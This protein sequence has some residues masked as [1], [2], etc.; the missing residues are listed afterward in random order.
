MLKPEYA[1]YPEDTWAGDPAQVI[2]A[3]ATAVKRFTSAIDVTKYQQVFGEMREEPISVG[4][5]LTCWTFVALWCPL[6]LWPFAS[7]CALFGA[8]YR[9]RGHDAVAF[10]GELYVAEA[11]RNSTGIIAGGKAAVGGAVKA[12]L[13]VLNIAKLVDNCSVTIE[14]LQYI[15]AV[16][17]LFVSI[18]V[19]A[20]AL[21]FSVVAAVAFVVLRFLVVTGMCRYIVWL[22]VCTQF[23]PRKFRESLQLLFSTLDALRRN[24][25]G[26]TLEKRVASFWKRIP[27]AHQHTH[28]ELCRKYVLSKPASN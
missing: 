14:K 2:Q 16:N 26:N 24:Y 7:V 10:K 6:W 15:F 22:L 9:V 3:A 19:G 18:V 12:S 17:D 5:L 20:A 4:V 23:L 25:L 1:E 28:L 21:A 27:D 8:S 13:T 11:Q